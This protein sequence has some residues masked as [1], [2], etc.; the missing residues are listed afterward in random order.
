MALGKVTE[1]VETREFKRYLGVCPVTIAAVNPT[2]EIRNKL[3]NTSLEEEPVYIKDATD[4]DG[5]IIKQVNINF[6]LTP[7]NKATGIEMQNVSMSIFLQKAYRY[8]S[9]K[10]KVQ[11]I[12]KFGDTTWLTVDDVKTK[13]Y[14]QPYTG[15]DVEYRPAIVGEEELTKLVKAFL[16]IK[17]IRVYDSTTNTWRVNPDV[18]PDDC[19]CRFDCLNLTSTE[20]TKVFTG[21]ISEIKSAFELMPNNKVKVMLGIRTNPETGALYQAVNTRVFAKSSSTSVRIFERE[22][23]NQMSYYASSGRTPNTEYYAGPVKEYVANPTTPE[24]SEKPIKT[25]E[26]QSSLPF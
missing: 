18:V 4:K 8:N 20:S 3:F 12:N 6:I 10:T 25:E 14:P 11:C 16:N 19:L 5:N 22:I 26:N 15:I 21:D 9:N 24:A 2:K 13:K 17:D 7:D 23:E 1:S